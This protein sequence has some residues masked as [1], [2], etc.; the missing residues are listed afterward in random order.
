MAQKRT[1]GRR[2][3]KHRVPGDAA[4]ERLDP[5]AKLAV[6]TLLAQWALERLI[7]AERGTTGGSV[8]GG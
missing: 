1:R 4:D 5:P 3:Q 8:D 7:S 2:A 6:D